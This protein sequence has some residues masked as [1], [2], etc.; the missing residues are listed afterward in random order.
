MLLGFTSVCLLELLIDERMRAFKV[1]VLLHVERGGRVATAAG[2]SVCTAAA[3]SAAT[4]DLIAPVVQI[5]V[6]DTAVR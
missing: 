6:L 3:A 2:T 4:V 5:V 1:I